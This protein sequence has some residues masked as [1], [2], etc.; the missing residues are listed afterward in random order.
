MMNHKIFIIV[1]NHIRASS[2]IYFLSP[3][4]FI[5]VPRVIKFVALRIFIFYKAYIFFIRRTQFNSFQSCV[6]REQENV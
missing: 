3:L 2:L 4:K 1:Y 5:Y 6:K